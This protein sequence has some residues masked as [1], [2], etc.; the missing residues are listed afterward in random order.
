[1][2]HRSGDDDQATKVVR[3]EPAAQRGNGAASPTT[4]TNA[5]AADAA[6]ANTDAAAPDVALARHGKRAAFAGV[7]DSR[8]G[9]PVRVGWDKERAGVQRAPEEDPRWTPLAEAQPGRSTL[10]RIR[11]HTRASDN[12]YAAKYAQFSGEG[13]DARKATSV[14]IWFP[15]AGER[16]LPLDVTVLNTA[17]MA[18]TIGYILFCYTEDKK[19]EPKMKVGTAKARSQCRL[20]FLVFEFAP[21]A[22]VIFP[23]P[24]F[25]PFFCNCDRTKEGS[26]GL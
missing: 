21:A 14:K 2:L 24:P 10:A 26:V 18:E 4:P 19:R 16:A 22:V 13:L 1:M 3:F 25:P 7:R 17:T 6:A 23:P 8:A 12:P 11:K 9:V 15:F 5:D 20:S